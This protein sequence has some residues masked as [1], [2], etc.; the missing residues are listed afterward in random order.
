VRPPN[1]PGQPWNGDALRLRRILAGL[2]A[3]ELA[4]QVSVTK[5]TLARWEANEHSPTADK[6]AALAAALGVR[7][8]AFA[9]KPRIV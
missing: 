1:D 4:A 2:S 7:K 9:R 5:S 3:Q 8:S 6:V